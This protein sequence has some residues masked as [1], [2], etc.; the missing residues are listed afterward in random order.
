[1][2]NY[3][4]A[5]DTLLHIKRV[6]ELLSISATELLKRGSQHDDSKLKD[7]EKP[8][9]D[10]M[11]PILKNLKYGSPEYHE[12]LKELNVA[13]HHHY[14]NN[15]HHPQHYANGINGMNLFDIIEMFFDWKAASERT[16]N[17]SLEESIKVNSERFDMSPQLTE[18][19]ENTRK[20][21]NL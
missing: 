5:A 6:S 4:S 10:K 19:F 11:T 13:L 12:S 21:M 14:A 15:S 18:I 1:M 17:G 3:D 8:L 2:E 9:F 16:A 20:Y 7:P